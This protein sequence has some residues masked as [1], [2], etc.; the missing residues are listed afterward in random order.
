[1]ALSSS[2][3]SILASA[4]IG[5]A[6]PLGVATMPRA[7]TPVLLIAPP[8]QSEAQAMQ[9]LATADA[10]LLGRGR[11]DGTLLVAPDGP[12]LVRRLY[13]AGA[14]LVLNGDLFTGCSP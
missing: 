3:R 6:L 13:A 11:F 2:C 8:G 1:M 9:I 10:R 5:L 7:A 4:L 12:D 14:F